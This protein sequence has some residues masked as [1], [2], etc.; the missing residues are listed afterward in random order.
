MLGRGTGL[1]VTGIWIE[2]RDSGRAVVGRLVVDS[3]ERGT[4][5]HVSLMVNC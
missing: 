4:E 1:L 3:P 2:A 5:R